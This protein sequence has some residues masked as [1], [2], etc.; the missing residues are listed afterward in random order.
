MLEHTWLDYL[1]GISLSL[2]ALSVAAFFIRST[3]SRRG[4]FWF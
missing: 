4:R 2:L 3:F 1:T